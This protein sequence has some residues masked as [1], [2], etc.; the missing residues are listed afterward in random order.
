MNVLTCLAKAAQ[1]NVQLNQFFEALSLY[2]EAAETSL[3]HELLRKST[4]K[5]LFLAALCRKALKLKHSIH[6]ELIRY[7]AHF[8][9]YRQQYEFLETIDKACCN[10]SVED[11][12]TACSD[13]NEEI[14][15]DNLATILLYKI[16]MD[17][18][19]AKDGNK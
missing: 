9:S 11:F 19:D 6:S 13:Y 10:L 15:L 4:Y 18:L 12:T 7:Y 8:G 16:K 14:E 1:M 2:E 17:L 5:Y 3:K